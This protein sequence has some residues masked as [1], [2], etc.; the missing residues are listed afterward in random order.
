[1]IAKDQQVFKKLIKEGTLEVLNSREGQEAIKKGSLAALKSAEGKDLMLDS[2]VE[3][4]H[5]VVVPVFEDYG[6][7]IK[8][9]ERKMG[10]AVL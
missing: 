1:M 3:G 8:N 4:F 9:L 6:D 10:A 2:F 5:E 7:R